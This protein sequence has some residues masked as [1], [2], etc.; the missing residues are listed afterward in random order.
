MG[1]DIQSTVIIRNAKLRKKSFLIVGVVPC[2]EDPTFQDANLTQLCF[3][4]VFFEKKVGYRW[5]LPFLRVLEFS[6][7]R[8][9]NHYST[10]A[11]INFF[12]YD[13]IIIDLYFPNRRQIIIG[14]WFSNR[15][16]YFEAT[17]KTSVSN[18][19]NGIVGFFVDTRT[20]PPFL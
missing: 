15:L 2:N 19:E 13:Q 11:A 6:S 12:K 14:L 9:S 7:S 18:S 4:F 3:L 8:S 5:L 10:F 17:I 16:Q 1:S 20:I